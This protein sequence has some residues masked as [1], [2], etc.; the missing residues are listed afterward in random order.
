MML[1][2]VL[3]CSAV[4]LALAPLAVLMT[5]SPAATRLIYATCLVTTAISLAAAL[6][7]LLAARTAE[8]AAFPVGVPWLGAHLRL[9]ALSAFFLAVV[10]LGAFSL[11]ALGY[12]EHETAPE[13]VLPFFPAF[14]AGMT[15]VVLADDAF[16]FLLSWEFMSLTSWALV[17]SHHRV[18]ENVRAGYIYLLM[19]SFGTLALLLA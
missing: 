14:L 3:A 6:A 5:R 15:L 12:G 8:V 19:A 18:P 9:D 16:T 7:H 13:R 1:S 10:D 11:F 2:A 17:M 4:L